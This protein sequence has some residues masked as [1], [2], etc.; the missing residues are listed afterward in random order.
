VIDSIPTII[1]AHRAAFKQGYS[2]SKTPFEQQ[3]PIWDHIWHHSDNFR[4]QLHAYFF[5]EEAVKKKE[6]HA[7]IWETSVVWQELIDDW[8]LCD[9]LAKINTK[10][11]ESY[12]V[13]IYKQ[14]AAWNK[15]EDLW[16]RRQS[17]VSLLYYS[18]TKKT[19]LPYSKLIALITPLLADKEYYVQKG[20]GWSLRELHTVYPA[21]TMPFLKK[22]IK[23]ISAIA[24][25]IAIEKMTA[26]EKD[27]LKIL[28][29]T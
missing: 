9:A 27:A 29:K 6:H 8:G 5:L 2:F 24:F 15:D 21:E 11:L 7:K 16:K 18:R 13:A 14:L 1:P 25:T 23:N 4:A 12:P 26:A 3:L 20:V 28:R 10:V 17:V 22:Y 19:Y